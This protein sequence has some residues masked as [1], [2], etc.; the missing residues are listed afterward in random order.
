M[1]RR[2]LLIEIPTLGAID[3]SQGGVGRQL[4]E[5]LRKAISRGELAAGERLPST[6]ALA[7]SLGLSRG[8]VN[9]A[10]EQLMA[11]GCLEARAGSGTQVALALHEPNVP[12]QRLP[13][14]RED[15]APSLPESVSRYAAMADKL[16]PLPSVPFS[17]AVPKD[18]VAM[19]DHWRRLSNRVRASP[20]AAP[21]G[22][23]DP[24]GLPALREAITEYLRKARAVIC[25]P[26]NIIVT[27]GTQQ[28]LYLA[29]KVLLSVGD[30][31][32]AED[33]AYPGLTAVLEERGIQVQRIAVD[34]QG[35]D[36]ARAVEA[37][38]DAKAAFVTPSHQYPMGMPLSMSRRLALIEWARKHGGWIVED[39]YD[40]ELR[41]A[42]HPFPAL[43][44]L[45]SDRVIYLGTFSKVLAPSLRLGY[46]VVPDCLV[47]AFV[48]ARALM[49][50]GSP[51]A[52]QHVVAAY[53]REGY[54][55]THIR[56]IRGIYA[57]RRQTLIDA[58]RLELPELQ[59]QPSD[60]GMHLVVW[61][62]N[63]L[64]DVTVAAAARTAGI[65][66]RPLSPMGSTSLKLSGLMLGFGGFSIDQ[67]KA[68]VQRLRQ[69]L[70]ENPPRAR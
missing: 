39:D 4:A 25:R 65:A 29:A 48:G 13:R 38:P 2:Q 26:E 21:S 40:S 63:E 67:I 1:P 3:R 28:G 36:V 51:L 49:G 59:I 22:Y 18:K 44:G 54:F 42:G 32:W 19:D 8:T 5:A 10:Y 62:P 12:S 45:D 69:V 24:R 50:R 43:Q 47:N 20:S 14:K 11:E 68:A 41:Y 70:E 33:P 15:H 37:S 17:I 57:E 56:R 6:R 58:L 31:A 34:A 60:Q 53:M 27:E 7:V 9:E 52:D 66:L 55:E 64:D 23:C 16:S 30:V 61:L 46:A 35:F